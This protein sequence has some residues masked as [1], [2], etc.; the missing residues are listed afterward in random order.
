MGKEIARLDFNWHDELASGDYRF[1]EDG[2]LVMDG[3]RGQISCNR[4]L[5]PMVDSVDSSLELS[6][7]VVLQHT[8]QICLYDDQDRLAVACRIDP[9][10]WIRFLKDDQWERSELLILNR[11]ACSISIALFRNPIKF[12]GLE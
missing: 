12:T 5:D 4:K 11:T 1:G 3:S 8:Y 6:F 10:G 9:H 2:Y 7:R